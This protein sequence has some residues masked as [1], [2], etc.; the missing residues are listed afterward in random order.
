MS[1]AAEVGAV[2]GVLQPTA[3]TG[4]FTGLAAWGLG[5]V[6]LT[7]N[8]AMVG[9]KEDLTV[10]TLAFSDVTSHWPESPQV[11]DLHI[12]AWQE[13]NGEEQKGG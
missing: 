3:L 7:P 2:W 5:T 1:R 13:E 11:N 6:A 4:R 10:L 12:T 9:I 8:S